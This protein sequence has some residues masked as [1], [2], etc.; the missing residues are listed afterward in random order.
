[1]NSSKIAVVA[2][3][4]ALSTATNYALIGVPNV[5]LMDFIVFMGGLLFGS[6]IGSSIGILSWL[7]YGTINPSGFVPQIWLATMFA[8][9]AYGIVGGCLRKALGPTAFHNQRFRLSILFAT[10]GFLPTVLYDVITNVAYAS[11]FNVPIAFAIFVS[12]AP[13]A[14]LHE[15]ANFAIFGICTIPTISALGKV[16]RGQQKWPS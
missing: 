4:C 1:M 6:I 15:A 9:S 8:E 2:V 3:F 16:T 14:V 7:V 10:M 5:K 12:G 13:F 11:V